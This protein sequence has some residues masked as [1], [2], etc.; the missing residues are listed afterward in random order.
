MSAKE[1]ALRA[2]AEIRALAG[3][4]PPGKYRQI[5]NKCN[6]IAVYIRKSN[7]TKNCKRK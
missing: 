3:G 5:Y 7:V 1:D 6:R 4:L 2:V